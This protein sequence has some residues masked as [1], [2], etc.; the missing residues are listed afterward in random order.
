VAPARRR[1][2]ATPTIHNCPLLNS[3]NDDND[4][5]DDNDNNHGDNDDD[6]DDDDGRPTS[7][8]CLSPA[9]RIARDARNV[10]PK[11]G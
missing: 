1:Q 11:P 6:D 4:D 7:W 10:H 2:S 8:A 5:N 3:G 9:A